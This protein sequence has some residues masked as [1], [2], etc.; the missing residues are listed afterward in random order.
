[1]K[2]IIGVGA[3]WERAGGGV[4]WWV[5]RTVVTTGPGVPRTGTGESGSVA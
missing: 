1:M 3:W 5:D 4:C 2:T